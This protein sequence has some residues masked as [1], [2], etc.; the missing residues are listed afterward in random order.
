MTPGFITH[1][2]VEYRY[3]ILIPLAFLEGP[4]VAFA[5]GVLASLG[6]FR[7]YELF[8]LFIARDLI[9]DS[10]YLMAG[11]LGRQSYAV[12]KVIAW[13]RLQ[14][15]ELDLLRARLHKHPFRSIVVAKLSYGIASTVIVSFG[16]LGLQYTRFITRAVCVTVLQYSILLMLGYYYSA[17]LSSGV[18]DVLKIVEYI[19]AGV[20]VV[21]VSYYVFTRIMRSRFFDR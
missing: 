20:V 10:A 5:A 11:H 13:L 19:M 17:S 18:T 14:P 4:V 6:Y 3:W 1:L 16:V 7:L 8:V 21:A 12:R 15:T 2:L 9:M